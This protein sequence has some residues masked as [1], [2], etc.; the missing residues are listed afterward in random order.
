MDQAKIEEMRRLRGEGKSFYRIGL[1]LGVNPSSVRYYTEDGFKEKAVLAVKE[2]RGKRPEL[3][4]RAQK[5]YNRNHSGEV[6]ARGRAWRLANPEK[7]RECARAWRSRN[8]IQLKI[9]NDHRRKLRG[10]P[11]VD[12]RWLWLRWLGM[13]VKE[14]VDR[15]LDLAAEKG[16]E[17]EW[18][19]GWEIDHYRPCKSFDLTTD[20]GKAV[21][22]HW[23][24]LQPVSKA[25]NQSKGGAELFGPWMDLG[26]ED[27]EGLPFGWKLRKCGGWWENGDLVALIGSGSGPKPTES[28]VYRGKPL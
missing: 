15:M 10:L 5:R 6:N 19:K 24:N 13:P 21:C 14:F 25:E 2:W 28:E 17:R 3:Y 23:S 22:F 11:L 9:A 27:L 7:Y 8:R 16:F 4:K 12:G 18:R 1:M 26:I 20:A